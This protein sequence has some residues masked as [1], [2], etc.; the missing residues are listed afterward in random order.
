M[1]SIFHEVMPESNVFNFGDVSYV[2]AGNDST[3]KLE[4]AE[5]NI[6][7]GYYKTEHS[8]GKYMNSLVP[9]IGIECLPTLSEVER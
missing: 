2:S 6:I 9:G 7:K 8:V 5:V 3:T 1:L 4:K